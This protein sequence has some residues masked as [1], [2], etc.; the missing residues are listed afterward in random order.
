MPSSATSFHAEACELPRKTFDADRLADV[1]AHLEIVLPHVSM[2]NEIARREFLIAPVLM[3]VVRQTGAD[4]K[5]EFPLEVE[6]RLKGTFD[7]FLRAT[8]NILVVEAKDGHLKRGFT[9]L[10]VELVALDRWL[11][12][13]SSESRF[14]GAVSM[15]DA[16]KFGYLDRGEKR[17]VED[18]NTYGIP[19]LLEDVVAI[20]LGVLTD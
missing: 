18:L 3:E 12:D 10:A 16:W 19:N 8:H 20:L 5:V 14:Y 2:T 1:K 11:G 15:G 9:Q 13:E 17:L 7:Y 6:E 4:L